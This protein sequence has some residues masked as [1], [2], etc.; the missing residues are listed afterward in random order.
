MRRDEIIS[1]WCH[2]L[3][4][5]ACFAFILEILDEVSSRTDII[6]YAALYSDGISHGEHEFG[7]GGAT[8]NGWPGCIVFPWPPR[9]QDGKVRQERRRAVLIH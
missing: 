9:L 7:A 1:P 5:W 3:V 8:V 4:R 6:R 2:F